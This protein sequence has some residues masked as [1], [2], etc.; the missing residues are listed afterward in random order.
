MNLTIETANGERETYFGLSDFQQSNGTLVLFWPPSLDEPPQENKEV[1]GAKAVS[2][3][4][5][6]VTTTQTLLEIAREELQ[7]DNRVYVG[8]SPQIKNLEGLIDGL[9]HFGY[10]ESENMTIYT[11]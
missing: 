4:D 3:G 2:A 10:D 9:R 5:E 1:E 11:R 7:R 8:A 6:S